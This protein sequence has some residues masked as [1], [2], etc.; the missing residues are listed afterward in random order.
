MKKCLL[1]TYLFN[2]LSLLDCNFNEIKVRVNQSK[3]S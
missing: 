2:K 3:E 1:I